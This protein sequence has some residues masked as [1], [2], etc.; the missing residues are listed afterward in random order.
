M[1][2][3]VTRAL[4]LLSIAV[5]LAWASG[6]DADTRGITVQLRASDDANAPVTETVKLYGSSHALVIGIDKY[7]GGW[8]RLSNAVN[9]ARAVAEE[10]DRQGFD[11]TLKTDLT[12]TRLDQSLKEFFAI[13][14]SDPNARLL[15]WYAGHGH[16]LRNEGYLVPAD[17]PPASSSRFLVNAIPMRS[18][19]T[20]VRF[21]QSKHV[22]AVFDSCFSG[23]VFTARAGAL[24]AAITKKTTKPV[25]QFLTSG[26]AGQ[27]VRDDGSFRKLF[28]RALRGE[29]RADANLDGYLT[30]EELG[31]FLSQE[32]ATLTE[33]AQ[34]PKH[35]KLHD[36]EFNQGD[37]VFVLPSGS[38]PSVSGSTGSAS[39][40]GMTAEMMFWASIKDSKNPAS[41][42]AY[43]S[44]YPR[45]TFAALARVRIA[46]LKTSQVA[47][48]PATPSFQVAPMDEEMVTAKTAYVRAMP[49]TTSSKV[50][51]LNA[52]T[53][54]DVTGK[55]TVSG[56]TWYRVAMAGSRTGYVFGTLLTEIAVSPQPSPA[57]SRVQPAVGVYPTKPRYAP[58]DTFKDCR[59][60]PEMVVVPAGSFRMGDLNGGG[61]DDEKP[62]HRV[63]I[64][65]TFAVGK[66]EVTQAEW[67]AVMGSNP[68]R[69][70][71][72]RYPVE[73]VN[74]NGAKEFVR[75]LSAKTGKTYR[76]LSEAEWEYTARAGSSTKYPW[77]NGINSSQAKFNSRDGTVPVGSYRPNAFGV[78]D[79]VGNVWEWVEDYWHDNYNGAPTNGSVWTIRD[80]WHRRVL[81][82]GSWYSFPWDVRSAFRNRYSYPGKG[83]NN[84][85]RVA[86]TF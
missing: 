11:V 7:T 14:G 33:A 55:A 85:F 44:Q 40:G 65:N 63:T 66:F 9:D 41:F 72:S 77:G 64:K 82:G 19:G 13:K 51:R 34:T 23:T 32:V 48:L 35:G 73:Q 50:G 18:F 43:L 58:G 3:N 61:G 84:G 78:Y 47:S 27:Q 57:P 69:Y 39:S 4:S 79:T 42:E 71:G 1:G 83:K 25:R 36:V 67:Q 38:T 68:S 8:P 74:W 86:R 37:F 52:G 62:V 54:V 49:S 24:P 76:L 46:E 20:L 2:T 12:A 75:K 30:G 16:T 10:L 81:R 21:A 26:D 53:K 5:V 6:A 45:G 15:L 22:L 56:A 60:C 31:L 59:E 70:K 17:A 80:R 28:L 29:E